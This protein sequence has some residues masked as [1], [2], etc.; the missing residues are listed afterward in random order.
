MV[1]RQFLPTGTG[2]KHIPT[3]EGDGDGSQMLYVDSKLERRYRVTERPVHAGGS[4]MQAQARRGQ[5]GA[6]LDSAAYL[7]ALA[8][9]LTFSGPPVPYQSVEE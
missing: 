7:A 2:S 9:L 8:E 5:V 1:W 3:K 4:V 6:A